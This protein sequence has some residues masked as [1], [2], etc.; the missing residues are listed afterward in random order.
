[1]TAMIL[2]CFSATAGQVQ[3]GGS[4]G[5]VNFS[6]TG[7]TVLWTNVPAVIGAPI[8]KVQAAE[9]YFSSGTSYLGCTN[10]LTNTV[11]AGDAI[12]AAFNTYSVAP[13]ALGVQDSL[14][15]SFVLITNKLAWGAGYWSYFYYCSN[16]VGGAPPVL[17][18]WTNSVAKQYN[19][20][21]TA[22][23]SHIKKSGNSLDVF[24]GATNYNATPAGMSC[25]AV[26][27]TTPNEVIIV[28]GMPYLGIMTGGAGFTVAV[29]SNAS[30]AIIEFTNVVTSGTSVGP[31]VND[32]ASTEWG[33]VLAGSFFTQ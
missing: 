9:F 23:F 3:L 30:L 32:S 25:P 18:F 15:D 24:S 1:M 12:F 6:K 10:S 13:T 21:A 4:G 29:S 8:T 14:G 2:T 17:V 33:C 20:L 19:F 28:A 26:T 5:T 7:G 22:E 16:T 11:N 27:T 31:A